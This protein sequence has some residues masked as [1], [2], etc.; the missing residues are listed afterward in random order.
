[1][2]VPVP[3]EP[4]AP[5]EIGV[6]PAS[7]QDRAAR[8]WREAE[9]HA[10]PDM[11]PFCGWDWTQH[12][13]QHFGADVPHHYVVGERNGQVRAAALLTRSRSTHGPLTIRRLHIGTAGE[14]AG[15]SVAV[16]Y[17]GLCA[18]PGDR[19]EF[20]RGLLDHVHHIGGWDELYLDGF[21]PD[22]AKALLRLEPRFT[23]ERRGSR[24]L[25]LALPT[26]D[27]VAVLASKSA[28]ST[29]RRSLRGLQPYSAHWADTAEEA[30]ELLDD[31]ERL[32]QKR[33][34]QRGE[35][36]VFASPQFRAFHRGLCE[37]WVP[38]GRAVVFGLRHEGTVVAAAYCLVVGDTLQYYQGGFQEF[39]DGKV[40]PGY[41]AHILLATEARRRGFRHYEYLAGD[42][43]YKFELSTDE[44]SLV[45]ARLTRR[46][47][48]A[49]AIQAARLLK[50]WKVAG[51]AAGVPEGDASIVPPAGHLAAKAR[52][53]LA[54]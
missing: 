9:T 17:N 39:D 21:H 32:H 50:T 45:W 26:D 46:H 23:T 53:L 35:P 31:L 2:P 19:A 12:W 41:A 6:L 36:G 4:A 3:V 47:P 25:D 5:L 34:Q 33:W 29:V 37:K 14:Q 49:L 44:R 48:R 15:T 1:M 22:H 8:A 18:A 42:H 38:E 16:E 52:R 51:T 13:L 27:L 54:R 11:P 20:A 30:L 28:R 43:R 24:V 40:R 10:G 7:V